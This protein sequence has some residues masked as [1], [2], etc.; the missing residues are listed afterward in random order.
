MILRGKLYSR[1]FLF[2]NTYLTIHLYIIHIS[3]LLSGEGH[4][5]IFIT[6]SD[7]LS[8]QN[9]FCASE[10]G[11]WYRG[12]LHSIYN[13]NNNIIKHATSTSFRKKY[14]QNYFWQKES[15]I[16][17]YYS[18]LKYLICFKNLICDNNKKKNCIKCSLFVTFG[19]QT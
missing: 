6:P 13:N 7:F 12:F 9:H 10:Q 19:K 8:L 2:L 11:S 5:L 15:L 14:K 18:F 17:N 3:T 4:F 16:Y 1:I